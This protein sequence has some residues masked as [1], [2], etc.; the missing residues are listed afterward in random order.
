MTAGAIVT[1][2][3]LGIILVR[4]LRLAREW[5]PVIVGIGLFI[6]GAVRYLTSRRD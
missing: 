5:I 4:E 1:M 2:V 3:G 6:L